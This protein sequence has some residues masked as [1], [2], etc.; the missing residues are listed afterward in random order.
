MRFR[1]RARTWG[2]GIVLA[3]ALQLAGCA[4]APAWAAQPCVGAPAGVPGWVSVVRIGVAR[5]WI[6]ARFFRAG[7]SNSHPTL[8]LLHGFPGAELNLD[9]AHAVRRA[10]WNVI[11]PHYRGA[12]G[13]PGNFTWRHAIAD[14]KA[15]LAWLRTPE[16]AADY[17]VD[18]RT[19]VVAGHSLGGFLALTAAAGDADVRGAVSLAGFNFGAVTAGPGARPGTEQQLAALWQE[20]AQWLSGASGA[21][22]AREAVQAGAQWDLRRLAVP[23]ARRPLLL[24]A[25]RYDQVAPPVLHHERLL[26]SLRAAHARTVEDVVLDTDHGFID[27]RTGLAERLVGWLQAKFPGDTHRGGR[28]GAPTRAQAA[29]LL[30]QG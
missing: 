11:V 1:R 9:L 8:L 16:A 19:L 23:L 14:A 13:T 4:A 6:G 25:A 26:Q 28:C 2:R 5:E 10:G 17:G 15:V 20:S 21:A 27:A 3:C 29:E 24:V 12:W 30:P 18:A 7:G 22:L